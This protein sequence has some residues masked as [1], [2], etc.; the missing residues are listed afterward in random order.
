M[1]Y[2]TVLTTLFIFEVVIGVALMFVG[3]MQA[4]ALIIA[5]GASVVLAHLTEL[6]LLN[7]IK[8]Q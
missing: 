7:K 4:N 5:L 1:N 3:S 8:S 6:F 2:R